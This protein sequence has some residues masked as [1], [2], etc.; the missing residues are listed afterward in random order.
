MFELIVNFPML[1]EDGAVRKYPV[2][3]MVM[4]VD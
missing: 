3:S 2:P 1:S 4:V